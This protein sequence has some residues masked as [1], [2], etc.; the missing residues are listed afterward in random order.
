MIFGQFG[1]ALI[2]KNKIKKISF[3]LIIIS[4]YLPDILLIILWIYNY[5][6]QV[7]GLEIFLINY[8]F[9]SHSFL[10][11]IGASIIIFIVFTALKKLKEALVIISCVMIHLGLDII[12][13]F[14]NPLTFTAFIGLSPYHFVNLFYP[15][16]GDGIALFIYLPDYLIW[17]IDFSILL[18]GFLYFISKY[19]E[20]DIT[21]TFMEIKD[22]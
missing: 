21:T 1:I 17:I 7:F 12:H 6:L 2:L 11:W 14:I 18:I 20:G 3:L 9:L 10:I 22:T 8:Y 19:A 4:L 16:F 15:L 13:P 5:I